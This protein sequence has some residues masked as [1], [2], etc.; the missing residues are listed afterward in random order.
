MLHRRDGSRFVQSA[1]QSVD[2]LGKSPLGAEF[3][4]VIE[5]SLERLHALAVE[6][7]SKRNHRGKCGDR[8]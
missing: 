4:A 1:V 3:S 7:K 8:S 2:S 6:D 5:C